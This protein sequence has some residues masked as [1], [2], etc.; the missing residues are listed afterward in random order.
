MSRRSFSWKT[1]L[2]VGG[3][4]VGVSVAALP[5]TTASAG[6]PADVV[7]SAHGSVGPARWDPYKNYRFVVLLN[8]QP[9]A[10]FRTVSGL[11]GVAPAT[12][13]LKRRSPA[14]PAPTAAAHPSVILTNGMSRDPDF[15]SWAVSALGG[16]PPGAPLPRRNLVIEAF[17]EAGHLSASYTVQH[18]WVV[19]YQAMPDLDAGASS[20]VIQLMKLDVE[21]IATGAH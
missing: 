2:L 21:G 7:R 13:Q 9:V 15:E 12:T 19:R 1:L 5:S 3:L 16:R 11:Q 10:G 4:A 17:D 20:V 14:V 8:G 6:T 18:A